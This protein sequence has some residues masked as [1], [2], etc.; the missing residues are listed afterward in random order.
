LQKRDGSEMPWI[1]TKTTIAKKAP[2]A[3]Q[4]ITRMMQ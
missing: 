3:Q 1:I 2:V 4:Q